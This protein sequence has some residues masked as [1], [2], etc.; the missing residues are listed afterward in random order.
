MTTSIAIPTIELRAA[1]QSP[2]LDQISRKLI[3]SGRLKELIDSFG[4]LGV[5]SNPSIFEKAINQK[6]GGYE[7][8]IL[9]MIRAGKSTF[10]IY[11][12]LTVAEI[13]TACDL[14]AKVYAESKGEHGY[15][16][17]EVMP[18]L[19]YDVQGTVREAK[20]L[21]AAVNRP[22]VM[23]KV[24]A[25]TEGIQAVRILIGFGININAT[26]I[27]TAA[28]YRDIAHAY[29]DGLQDLHKA[30]GKLERVRSV[31]S[32]FVS[33]FD[34]L[35]DKKIEGLIKPGMD[36]FSHE[37]VAGLRGKAAIAN[38]KILF[39]EF[40]QIFSSPKFTTLKSHG[41][42]SQKLLWGSTSTK[43]PAYPEL[44]YVE[45]LIGRDTVNTIPMETLEAFI[46][47]GHVHADSIEENVAEA[48]ETSARMK[49]LGIDLAEIGNQ[50]QKQG[51]IA[52]CES[53]DQLMKS[54]ESVR[55]EEGMAN[56]SERSAKTSVICS[57]GTDRLRRTVEGFSGKLEKINFLD[58]FLAK[59]AT[60]WKKDP[61]HIAII[62]QRLGWLRV[63]DWMLGQVYLLE[64]LADEVRERKIKDIVL[65]GMG[66]SSLAPEVIHLICTKQQRQMPRFHVLDTTDPGTIL[67]VESAIDMSSTLFVVASKSGGTIEMLSQF[68]YF[69]SKVRKYCTK[70]DGANPAGEHFIAITDKGSE[71]EKLAR[72]NCFRHIFINPSDIGGRYSALSFFGLVPAALMGADFRVLLGSASQLFRQF[73]KETNV[74]RNPSISLG[75]FLAAFAKSGQSDICF[76]AR[77]APVRC[78]DRTADSRKYR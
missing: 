77:A 17:L 70:K 15:V 64:R 10:D 68:R 40:R 28:Q 39:Q 78:M 63:H 72:E 23:I 73:Q 42:N 19:S 67:S 8:D 18:A 16:S 57:P 62:N 54:I 38:S 36:P 76:V 20:R 65:L 12:T 44:M 24:P 45:P 50:L 75:A 66:G 53:F 37:Q 1:G 48:Y 47:H 27:F 74:R 29:L 43:N 32:V 6:G 25:T 3:L 14:F 5:T 7:A 35:I 71:L 31:A 58:R 26:L 41:A 69:F 33:R 11:D 30:G 34:S 46:D 56:K 52:F 59:D 51:V 9:K 13:R 49:A 22:N 61:A 60:L 4:L 21:F 55:L 2:W